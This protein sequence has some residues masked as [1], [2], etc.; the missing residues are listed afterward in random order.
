MNHPKHPVS[1]A[2]L[3]RLRLEASNYS[4]F[5]DLILDDPRS[6]YG[7]QD[8]RF[9]LT[10]IL[11]L[12]IRLTGSEDDAIAWIMNSGGYTDA[13]NDDVCVG[14]AH[15]DFWTLAAHYDWLQVIYT[16]RD[17]CPE[18]VKVVFRRSAAPKR[19]MP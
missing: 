3:D 13:V 8:G 17:L 16:Y 18:L 19:D 15:G 14:L 1:D 4:D 5:V 11:G 9:A 2:M 10:E 12:L 6:Q 7:G